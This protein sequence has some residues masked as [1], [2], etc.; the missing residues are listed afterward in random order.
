[1]AGRI[2]L[3]NIWLLFLYAAD[4]VRFNDARTV[5]TENARDLPELV[6][7]LLVQV[8][9]DRMRRNLSRGYQNTH[10]VLPRVRGR[11]DV[12][13]TIAHRRLE[14]GRVSC[15]FDEHTMD[16]PRNCLVRA[17]LIHLSRSVGEQSV[18]HDCRSISLAL[19]RVGVSDTK[20][21][22]AEMAADQVSR[23]ETADLLM[24]G[25]ARMVFS[26]LIPSE[27]EGMTHAVAPN[28]DAYL[29]RRLFEK[30]VGNA[31][32]IQLHPLG[33]QVRHGRQ[34]NWPVTASSSVI[35]QHLPR[36]ET[37]IELL[38]LGTLRKVV[39]DTK[40]TRIF[41]ATQY[42]ENVLR[43]GY[44][45]QLYAYLRTQEDSLSASGIR[46]EGMLLH[47]QIGEALDE[48]LDIQGHRMRF[49]TIDLTSSAEDFE[50]QLLGIVLNE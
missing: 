16:T 26:T 11:I 41:G 37:D 49:K 19:G 18:A 20:P 10:A 7:R 15:R 22:R 40:F 30:A 14:Q 12:L 17:A 32:R 2:P 46:S 21:S 13:D 39:I 47:P 38:H 25:L 3:R 34:L 45:Y 31:L 9:Q 36:M 28:A 4:L 23:N 24:V 35:S 29:L 42:R 8:V 44:L 50:R 6:A 5:E 48:Y 1:M 27:H 33:W 43:S